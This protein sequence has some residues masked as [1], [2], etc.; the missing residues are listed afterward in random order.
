MAL[1][2]LF[3]ASTMSFNVSGTPRRELFEYLD[4]HRVRS[5]N[6]AVQNFAAIG[7]VEFIAVRKCRADALQNTLRIKR[8]RDR[9]G[10]AQRPGLHRT[11]MKGVAENEQPRN[12]T[13]GFGVE[14]IA[15]LLH[16]LGRAQIDVDHDPG[17]IAGGRVGNIRR[18]NGI[19]LAPIAECRPIRCCDGRDRMP[20]AT[21]AWAKSGCLTLS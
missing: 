8:P 16:A 15:N 17:E 12:G 19:D 21:G 18:R 11:M 5:G 6:A 9:I 20:A 1:R 7:R 13:V 2:T 14:L 3:S 10:C 4:H